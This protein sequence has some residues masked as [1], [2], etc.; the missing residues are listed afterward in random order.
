MY[1]LLAGPVD[2]QHERPLPPAGAPF[3]L[4]L[5]ARV[6]TVHLTV[7]LDELVHEARQRC[8]SDFAEKLKNAAVMFGLVAKTRKRGVMN[9][10]PG[11]V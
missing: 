1:A 8:G 9:F 10:A 4:L 7:Q 11:P 6:C 2:D 3:V 5:D